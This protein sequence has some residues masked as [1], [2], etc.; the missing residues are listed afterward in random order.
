MINSPESEKIDIDLKDDN[1]TSTS[2]NPGQLRPTRPAP[3]QINLVEL[4]FYMLKRAWLICLVGLFGAL[5]IGGYTYLFSTPIYQSSA[6]IYIAD[7]N[8]LSI[9]DLQLGSSLTVD[10]T[11]MANTQNVA[12]G[13]M[14]SL[15]IEDQM[16]YQ[17]F[18]QMINVKNPQDSHMLQITA[19]NPDPVTAA[20]MANAMAEQLQ[21]QI[22]H[23]MDTKKPSTVQKALVPRQPVGPNLLKRM[24]EGFILAAG[25]VCGIYFFLFLYKDTIS[26]EEDVEKHLGLTVISSIGI[27]DHNSIYNVPGKKRHKHE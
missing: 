14:T 25:L 19:T 27:G 26:S 22:A 8:T 13:A 4:F 3:N 7:M 18:L 20:D 21:I 10:Y 11:I 5:L 1:K 15:G 9:Q 12:M 16:T 6:T 2:R 23:I 17:Q 24:A